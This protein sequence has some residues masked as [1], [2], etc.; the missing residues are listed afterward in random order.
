MRAPELRTQLLH[1]LSQP[2]P[3]SPEWILSLKYC[4]TESRMQLSIS[5]R[6]SIFLCPRVVVKERSGGGGQADQP[7]P[8]LPFLDFHL[9]VPPSDTSKT[10]PPGPRS[11]PSVLTLKHHL[12]PEEI[13]PGR[14]PWAELQTGSVTDTWLHL[15]PSFPKTHGK[16]RAIPLSF[17]EKSAPGYK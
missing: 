6:S 4:M 3:N 2:C 11:M 7:P 8:G 5:R 9:K 10:I 13:Y 12:D 15:W 1:N 14:L 16:T 17:I